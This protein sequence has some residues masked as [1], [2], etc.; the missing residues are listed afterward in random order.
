M[1]IGLWS[2]PYRIEDETSSLH[3][4][5]PLVSILLINFCIK[6]KKKWENIREVLYNLR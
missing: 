6:A 1:L 2:V 3:H 5:S 4:P